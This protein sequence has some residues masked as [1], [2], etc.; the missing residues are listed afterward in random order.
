MKSL[1]VTIR[2]FDEGDIPNKIKWINDPENNK[3][4]HYDL[5]LEYEKT[6]AWYEACKHRTDRYDAVILADG[7][8]VGLIGLLSIDGKNKKA[9]YYVSMGEAEYKGRGVAREASRLIVDYAFSQLLLDKLYL[10]TEVENIPAQRLFESVGFRREGLIRGDVVRGGERRD[11]YAYG[12]TRDE[13]IIPRVEP[14]PIQSL[15]ECEGNKL[16]IK[17]DDLI[18]FSFGGNKARK[19]RLFFADMDEGVDSVVTYGSASSNHARIVANLAA[20]RGLECYIITPNDES[21]KTFNT[22]LTECFGARRIN[23]SVHYVKRVIERTLKELRDKGKNPYFIAGGGHGNLGTQ[24]YVECFYEILEYERLYGVKFDYVFHASGTG[25]T[26]AGLIAGSLMSRHGA[27]IVGIS[28][29]RKGEYGASV[30]EESVLDYL[31]AVGRTADAEEVK[32]SLCFTD[33]YVSGGYGR[34]NGEIYAVID[35][36]MKKHGIP[37]DPTYTGKAM[38]GTLEYLRSHGISG[39]NIL[40]IHTGGAPLYFEYLRRK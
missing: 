16:Y 1:K 22:D 8:P 35:D 13:A 2:R 7:V 32:E 3:Y 10:Y 30:I 29:A 27:K 38:Y 31:H 34:A 37:L 20:A 36:F 6:L 28:I 40:F 21:G 23:C 24:A 5:P 17:R 18:P 26:Q 25:T 9:E 14:T 11:R 19:A 12:L 15:G 33:E 39:K 4:L